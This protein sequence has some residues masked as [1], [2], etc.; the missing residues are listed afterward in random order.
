LASGYGA[1]AMAKSRAVAAV[2]LPPAGSG[3][4]A[5]LGADNVISLIDGRKPPATV[6]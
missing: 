1:E 4:R 6:A 3:A 5:R 2:M